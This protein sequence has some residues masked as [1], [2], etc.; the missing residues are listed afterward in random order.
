MKLAI[1]GVRDAGYVKEQV[2]RNTGGLWE[3]VILADNK[4]ELWD[5]EMDLSEIK[6]LK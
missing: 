2:E 6:R 3:V 1:F 4:E 5:T